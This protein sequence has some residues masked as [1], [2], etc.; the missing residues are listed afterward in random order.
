MYDCSSFFSGVVAGG[1][2]VIEAL[3]VIQEWEV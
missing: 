1:T 2:E 3:W